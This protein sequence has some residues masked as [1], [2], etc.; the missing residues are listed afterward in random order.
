MGFAAQ[1]T[2]VQEAGLLQAQVDL[3]LALRFQQL[4]LHKRLVE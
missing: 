4:P 3:A 2:H 1:T